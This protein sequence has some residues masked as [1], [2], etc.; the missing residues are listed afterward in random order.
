MLHEAGS[1]KARDTAL[2]V[3]VIRLIFQSLFHDASP[4]SEPVSPRSTM[5]TPPIWMWPLW[6]PTDP[7]WI[8]AAP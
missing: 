1:W 3:S 2:S 8:G 7:L 5:S 4:G 6:S